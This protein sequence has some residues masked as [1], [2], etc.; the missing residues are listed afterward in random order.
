M[1]EDRFTYF[2]WQYSPSASARYELSER[3]AVRSSIGRSYRIPTFTDLYYKDSAN[4]GN[5]DLN[6]ESAW[7]YEAGVD[8]RAAGIFE[9]S[10]TFFRRDSYDTID[11]TRSSARDPWRVSNIGRIETNGLEIALSL[12]PPRVSDAISVGRL[13]LDYTALDQYRKHDYL[14][15]Y[16]LDY[17]KQQI[18]GAIDC[19]IFGIRN[20]WAINYK[21]RIGDSGYIVV[22]AAFSK[23]IL[24]NGQAVVE[25]FL[26]VTNLFDE[27]YS[28]QSDIPMPGRW[29]K[30]GA[31]AKF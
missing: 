26:D 4:I 9:F 10:G 20:I 13:S 3:L 5:A 7:N 21:K 19:D 11:W 25:A 15:K 8:Y 31:R 27:P 18:T 2:G 29:I 22:D 23:A 12:K 30:S 24:K 28:E 6:P 1:R 16:A 17:L 14:S